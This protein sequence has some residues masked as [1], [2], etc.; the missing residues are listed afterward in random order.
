MI[1]PLLVFAGAAASAALAARAAA[2]LRC[3]AAVDGGVVA[4]RGGLPV[5][6]VVGARFALEAGRG[7]TAV[8]VRPALL[9]AVAGV[10][11]VLGAFTFS[12]GVA[13]AAGHPE[14]FGQTWQLESFVGYNGHDVVPKARAGLA[15]IARDPDVAGVDDARMAVAHGGPVDAA[16]TLFAYDPVGKPMRTVVV[17]GRMPGAD[18]EVVLAPRRRRPSTPASATAS[19]S[20]RTPDRST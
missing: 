5:P 13:D 8:P 3:R 7:R 14:R 12:S 4:A 1:V 11:G 9:G 20:Q 15:A 16:V 18:G 6:V 19:G 2:R 10:L 17:D